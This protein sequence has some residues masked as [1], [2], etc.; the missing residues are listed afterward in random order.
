MLDLQSV[1]QKNA[2]AAH[3]L[4]LAMPTLSF[5]HHFWLR[6]AVPV[7]AN[8][9]SIVEGV[10]EGRGSNK[11]IRIPCEHACRFGLRATALRP[12]QMPLPRPTATPSP[13]KGNCPS[14]A[15]SR[16]GQTVLHTFVFSSCF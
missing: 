13:R 3:T 8:S 4:L 11:D 1:S 9:P 7:R 6:H 12:L 5:A 10:P 14:T 2:F 16:S 15:A